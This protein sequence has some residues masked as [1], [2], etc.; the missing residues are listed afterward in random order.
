MEDLKNKDDVYM[1]MPRL[2][3][4]LAKPVIISGHDI[5]LKISLGITLY[6]IDKQPPSVLLVHADNAMYGIKAKKGDRK[7]FWQLYEE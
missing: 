6:P 3:E 4:A 5:Y 7:T 2:E 1:L